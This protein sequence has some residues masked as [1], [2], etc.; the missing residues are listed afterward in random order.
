MHSQSA[1]FLDRMPSRCTHLRRASAT[2]VFASSNKWLSEMVRNRIAVQ[3]TT[4][5]RKNPPRHCVGNWSFCWLRPLPWL[6]WLFPSQFS[7]PRQEQKE[8][9]RQFFNRTPRIGS[10][11]KGVVAQ[12]HLGLQKVR[13]GQKVPWRRV[14]KTQSNVVTSWLPRRVSLCFI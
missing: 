12:I 9:S 13:G 14:Y 10:H 7:Y 6:R 8:V 1:S 11:L 4:R 3:A 5:T 2:P